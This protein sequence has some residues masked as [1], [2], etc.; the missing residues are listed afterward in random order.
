MYQAI[1]F[2]PLLGA[3]IA[4]LF[5]TS[6]FRNMGS[7]SAVYGG[8]GHDAHGHDGHGQG[9]DDHGGHYHGPMWPMYLTTGLLF[10]GALLARVNLV[11][12]VDDRHDTKVEVLRWITPG[13]LQSPWGYRTAA[14]A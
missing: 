11:G 3:I 10:V 4:G 1:V 14:L 9:H 13:T 7:D 2:L 12:I 8:H 5:G 6:L